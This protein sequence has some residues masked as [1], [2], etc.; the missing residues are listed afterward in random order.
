MEHLSRPQEVVTM[1]LV[2][3]AGYVKSSECLVHL[4]IRNSGPKIFKP[5]QENIKAFGKYCL[6][7]TH[8]ES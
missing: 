3:T 5:L 2:Y 4:K 6:V 8:Y 1:Y 7:W